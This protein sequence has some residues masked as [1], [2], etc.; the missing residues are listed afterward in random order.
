MANLY[1]NGQKVFEHLAYKQK[2]TISGL[3]TF[4]HYQAQLIS[5]D[6]IVDTKDFQTGPQLC[7][8][9]ARD[10]NPSR[11]YFL[12][13][14][15]T[16]SFGSVGTNNNNSRDT[17]PFAISKSDLTKLP[18]KSDQTLFYSANY[19]IEGKKNTGEMHIGFNSATLWE[20]VLVANDVSKI[21]VQDRLNAA[22]KYSDAMSTPA[23][24]VRIRLNYVPAHT[25]VNVT[26]PK[27]EISNQ[28]T[29]WTPAPEDFADST[30]YVVTQVFSHDLDKVTVSS[31]ANSLWLVALPQFHKVGDILTKKDFTEAYSL[32]VQNTENA[33]LT[34]LADAK[35]SN[36]LDLALNNSISV[37]NLN[38]NGYL[39]EKIA[40]E[41]KNESIN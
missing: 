21:A 11:N 26:Q 28:A 16:M 38:V 33:D 37:S 3:Q 6:Q 4:T 2:L 10:K 8:V 22:I 13:S 32:K 29:D 7:L 40:M 41:V 36:A 19:Q 9:E 20:D 27:L 12:N 18:L 23:T 25:T 34:T 24:L 31:Q 14:A 15:Q 35:S 5:N 30:K 17:A 1:L 39:F